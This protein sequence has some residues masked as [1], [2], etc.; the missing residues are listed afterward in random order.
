MFSHAMFFFQTVKAD[1]QA[2]LGG[3]SGAGS[4]ISSLIFGR[5]F[6]LL[7]SY[8]IQKL[9]LKI[10]FI[11]K[12]FAKILQYI[13]SCLT[14]CEISFTSEINGGVYIP[15]PT[16]I[17]IGANVRIGSGVTIYQNVTIGTKF[18]GAATYIEIEDGVY[19]GAGSV[20]IGTIKIGKNSII[21]AN[22]VVTKDVP[23]ECTAMGIPAAI[24]SNKNPDIH[25]FKVLK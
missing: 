2:H 14:A 24:K 10:P 5:G 1:F 3:R 9:V 12:F 6:H 11:G 21:G 8:R 22:A 16:G 4:T 23:K 13:T 7:L 19:I 20:I 17:V 15:H 18:T 25:G